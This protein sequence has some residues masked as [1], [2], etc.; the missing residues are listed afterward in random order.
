MS[1]THDWSDWLGGL[2][3]EVAKVEEI[4]HFGR[5]RGLVLE[6]IVTDIG[7]GNNQFVFRK[8]SHE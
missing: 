8:T 6:N 5:V 4:F 7:H 2:P 3:F 1:I